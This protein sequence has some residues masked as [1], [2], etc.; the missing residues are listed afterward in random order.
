MWVQGGCSQLRLWGLSSTRGGD[1]DTCWRPLASTEG[2]CLGAGMD[3]SYRQPNCWLTTHNVV[4]QSSRRFGA[5]R[6]PEPFLRRRSSA[7]A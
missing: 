5:R 7:A 4:F 1:V 6:S 2:I 3:D